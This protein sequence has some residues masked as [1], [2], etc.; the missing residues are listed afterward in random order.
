MLGLWSVRVERCQQVRA[1]AGEIGGVER[2][3]GLDQ[4]GDG[5]V[6]GLVVEVVGE[7]PH[8]PQ[9]DARVLLAD[10]PRL[11]R[12]PQLGAQT[13]ELAAESDVMRGVAWTHATPVP[14][15]GRRAGGTGGSGHPALLECGEKGEPSRLETGQAGVDGRDRVEKVA[16]G[17]LPL[18]AGGR[19]RDSGSQG[20]DECLPRLGQLG[21]AASRPAVVVV[22]A[23]GHDHKLGPT[24]DT[25]L[26][27]GGW[28]ARPMRR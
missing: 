18:L 26:G 5:V 9:G 3:R 23:P 17:E 8:D 11:Q 20:A 14:Q 2:G 16:V 7:L 12:I 27:R 15:E 6:A 4:G 22:G 21:G 13:V 10:R 1:D 19:H 24:S 25:T 28:L